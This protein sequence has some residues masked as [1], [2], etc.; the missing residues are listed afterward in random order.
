MTTVSAYRPTRKKSM[1]E[2]LKRKVTEATEATNH[3]ILDLV[4]IAG[5][6]L[7]FSQLIEAVKAINAGMGTP[8]IYLLAIQMAI[9]G[10]CSTLAY[11]WHIQ[12]KVFAEMTVIIAVGAGYISLLIGSI[13][14]QVTNPVKEPFYVSMS[15]MGIG[16]AL[17][18]IIE[19]IVRFHKIETRKRQ[20][21]ASQK[22]REIVEIPT[23]PEVLEAKA[24]EIK[25]IIE[26]G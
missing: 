3:K 20:I 21:K 9:L 12:G 26:K 22:M 4:Y 8:S 23:D 14:T 6:V 24:E 17:W 25:Q 11:M 2:K 15:G 16:L 7:G 19:L 5:A 1:T 10:T 13:V 18:F